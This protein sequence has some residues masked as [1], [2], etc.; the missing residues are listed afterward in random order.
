[1]SRVGIAGARGRQRLEAE[2]LH[3]TCAANIP[4]IGN[5]EAPALMQC[6]ERAA[7]FGDTHDFVLH[8]MGLHNASNRPAIATWRPPFRGGSIVMK[9]A[10]VALNTQTGR[11]FRHRLVIGLTLHLLC[12]RATIR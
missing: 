8:R 4:G 12:V 1:M 7:F 3:V 9:K 10:K 11:I 6:A 2:A 5:D